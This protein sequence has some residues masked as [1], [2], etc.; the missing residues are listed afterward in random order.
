[1]TQC[2]HVVDLFYVAIQSQRYQVIIAHC[3]SYSLI[4][5]FNMYFLMT[6]ELI[7]S[8]IFKITTLKMYL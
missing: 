1:M 3:Y 7:L 4:S 8:L 2:Q 5:N 6:L